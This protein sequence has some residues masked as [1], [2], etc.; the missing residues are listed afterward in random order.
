MTK[1]EVLHVSHATPQLFIR[2]CALLVCI[3]RT[4]SCPAN[5]LD[6][7]RCAFTLNPGPSLIPSKLPQI[8]SSW[9]SIQQ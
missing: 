8:R 7:S 6:K 9:T 1:R 3:P 2:Q 4:P 5:A